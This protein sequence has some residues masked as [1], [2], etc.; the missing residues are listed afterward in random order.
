M[1]FL[2]LVFDTS[3]KET[4]AKT[5]EQICYDR[6][7]DGGLENV[8]VF[9]RLFFSFGLCSASDQ[10]HEK[11]DFNDTTE[12][13]FDEDTDDTRKFASEFLTSTT[14]PEREIS[15]CSAR[16]E[17]R[18]HI[19]VGSGNH[20]N[21]GEREDSTMSFWKSIADGDSSG[22]ERPEYVEIFRDRIGTHP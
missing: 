11:D 8:D 18:K 22:D 19:H 2:I 6:T 14:N 16:G 4:G 12:G 15:E 21:V 5:Q 10:D 9:R 20:G 7:D 1:E 17:Y 13:G 3:D